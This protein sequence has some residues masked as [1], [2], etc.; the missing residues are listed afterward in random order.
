MSAHPDLSRIVDRAV[1][2]AIGADLAPLPEPVLWSFACQLACGLRA[3]HE[4]GLSFRG[5]HAAQVLIT[6]HSRARISGAG[7]LDVLEAD[8]RKVEAAEGQEADMRGLGHML[9]QLATRSPLAHTC[10]DASLDVVKMRYSREMHAII[11]LL[12]T[13]PRPAAEV[14]R[15][16]GPQMA[17][18]MDK[19]LDHADA[20]E[21]LLAR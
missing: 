20:M 16:L 1:D 11:T 5:I 14:C 10:L 21:C 6:G 2:P 9:L 15:L 4:A 13:A 8:S 17:T 19:L 12:S 18:E 7:L 3:A